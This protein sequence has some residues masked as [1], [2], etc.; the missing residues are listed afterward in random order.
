MREIIDRYE[1]TTTAKG[2]EIHVDRNPGEVVLWYLDRG[3]HDGGPGRHHMG[4]ARIL[5][6]ANVYLVGWLRGNE[7]RSYANFSY[8]DINKVFGSLDEVI[9]GR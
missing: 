7:E 1:G 6:Q 2:H 5:K 9:A 8:W 4:I 3:E